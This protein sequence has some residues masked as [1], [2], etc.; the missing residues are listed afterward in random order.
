MTSP[1]LKEAI[2]TGTLAG[3]PGQLFIDGQ[4]RAAASRERMETFDPG[5]GRAFAAFD[6]GN[7]HDVSE[8]VHSAERAQRGIWRTMKPA[9]RC[10]ILLKAAQLMRE[11]ADRLSVVETLDSGKT[12]TEAQWDVAA[13]ARLFEYY[14]GLADKLQGDTIPLGPDYL[15]Y[16]V[17]EPVGVTAHIIPW[18]YPTST[19]VRGIAPALA[20]GCTAVV[21]P[22]ETT[23]LTAL[24]IAELLIKAGLPPGVCN[25]VTGTGPIAGAALVGHP[26]VRHV[27]FTGSVATGISAMQAAARNIASV[28]LELGG[29]SPMI[30]F[31]DADMDAAVEGARW[32]IYSNAGQVCSA[33]SRLIVERKVHDQLVERVAKVSKTLTVGH[34]LRNPDMGAINSPV[35]LGR[36]AGYVDDA[37]KR[38]LS[39]A[40]GGSTTV[41]QKS[42]GGWFFEPTLI[43]NVQSDDRIVQEEIFGPVMAVQ[44]AD[45]PEQALELA[46][47]TWFGLVAGVYTRDISK[48]LQLARD[49]DAGQIYINEYYAGGIEVPFGG[50]KHSGFGREKGLEGV[51]A[52]TRVKAVTARI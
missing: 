17:A 37:K 29:K 5:T 44:V 22:A 48:A 45:S 35:Q 43:D 23:P 46:N 47:D 28:T 49:L 26:K 3:L 6:A 2:E 21:K 33:G 1:H 38:G 20:A 4:W 14:A 12:I 16:T 34:G 36:I 10:S 13:S 52:Y 40:T 50:N 51:K 24:M 32:A 8:A 19:M 11:N 39:I 41:D 42:G 27:T 9:Q 30:V 15:S 31:A 25:V 7:G 18:N